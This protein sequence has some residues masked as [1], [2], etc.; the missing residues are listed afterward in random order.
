MKK[1]VCPNCGYEPVM[2]AKTRIFLF[3]RHKAR[4]PNCKV[5]I[6]N[7]SWFDLLR[8]IS[9]FGFVYFS[10]G[11]IHDLLGQFPYWKVLCLLIDALFYTAWG[12]IAL[13]FVPLQKHWNETSEK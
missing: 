2:S 8:V 4:C 5:A 7:P 12:I 6:S 13:Y 1:V 3:Y 10:T 11:Y 9:L